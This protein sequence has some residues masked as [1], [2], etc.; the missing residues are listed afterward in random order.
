MPQKIVCV[1]CN[2][3]MFLQNEVRLHLCA[4]EHKKKIEDYKNKSQQE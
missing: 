3:T 1:A 4:A 2:Y